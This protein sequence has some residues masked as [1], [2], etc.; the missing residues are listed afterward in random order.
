MVRLLERIKSSMFG[1][2]FDNI[3]VVVAFVSVPHIS[4]LLSPCSLWMAGKPMQEYD[5]SWLAEYIA[6]K[7]IV[8]NLLK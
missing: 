3:P 5:A 1:G 7:I 6:D 4:S 8:R 2:R